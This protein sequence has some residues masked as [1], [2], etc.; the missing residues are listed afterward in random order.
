[1]TDRFVN[2]YTFVKLRN[3]K[4]IST[5]SLQD[6]LFTGKIVC[7]MT[8]KTQIAVPDNADGFDDIVGNIHKHPFYRV[9]GK[10]MIPGSGIRGVIRNT[11]EALTNSCMRINDKDD[12]Y[13]SSRQN[14]AE[15][16]LLENKDG[17]YILHKAKRYR[18]TNESDRHFHT[19]DKIN[20]DPNNMHEG[21]DERTGRVES[22][23]A[24]G[25]SDTYQV[26]LRLDD[27]FSREK[28]VFEIVP[29][30][31]EIVLT[32]DEKKDF[33]LYVDRYIKR[34]T[35]GKKDF[36]AR[37]KAMK[38]G[39]VLLPVWY[40]EEHISPIKEA[41][42]YYAGLMAYENGAYVLYPADFLKVS[43]KYKG[44]T[45]IGESVTYSIVTEND[46]DRVTD[47]SSDNNKTCIYYPIEEIKNN[48]SV[49]IASG[50]D[51]ECKDIGTKII[52]AFK[53]NLDKYTPNLADVGKEYKDAFKKM[54]QSRCVLPVWYF[55][56][57]D[58]YYLA[59]SQMSR[60][61]FL[62]KPRDMLQKMDYSACTTSA[63][64]C[65]AC[66]LFGMIAPDD[67]FLASHVRFGDAV[68]D[69]ENCF[70]NFYVLPIL[71][72]PRLSSFEFYL[73]KRNN[74]YG[75]ITDKKGN[76]WLAAYDPDEEDVVI[77]GRKF[78]WHHKGKVITS[79]DQK[80]LDAAKD[81]KDK[82]KDI[83]SSSDNYIELV[84]AGEKFSFTVYFDDI[85]EEQLKKLVFALN[86]GENV[87][88][89]T[90]CHKI[91]HGKPIGLGSVKITVDDIFIREYANG[92]YTEKKVTE[93]YCQPS[94][95]ELF[96]SREYDQILK[97]A[98]MD[99]I[100]DSKLIMYPRTMSDENAFKWFADN[101]NQLRTPGGMADLKKR[102]PDLTA[103]GQTLPMNIKPPKNNYGGGKNGYRR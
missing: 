6:K 21:N 79:H 93:E 2:P 17:K 29:D 40:N 33:D 26:Y 12:D 24:G 95:E 81:A 32:A 92:E 55:K 23:K 22:L 47:I 48:P 72:E 9:G 91:G 57:G 63:K 70:D 38:C 10:A 73:R 28:G 49:F 34:N 62:N 98:N 102:L 100:S 3:G 45:N 88:D 90:L 96:D 54:H 43:K 46:E 35:S 53:V 14:K 30:Q 84:K 87:V 78:Y 19:G 37:L 16:G 13:F 71:S 64:M 66:A 65:E 101:R 20:I 75:H 42:D 97:V 27:F 15:P 82:G 39:G 25:A 94:K 76:E 77:A 36:V 86:F 44:R 52:T 11:Y 5:V 1:M 80:A 89:S 68:C 61:V 41:K 4:T 51:I 7:T 69:N 83:F 99:T 59:P 60:S 56:R 18:V 103:P 85:T 58:Q 8:T 31:E 50:K 67:N 74:N